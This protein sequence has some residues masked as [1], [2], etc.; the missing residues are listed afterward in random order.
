M[1]KWNVTLGM[2]VMADTRKQ[3]RETT[4]RICAG[5]GVDPVRV[6]DISNEPVPD[7]SS[8]VAI[9]ESGGK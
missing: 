6:I 1:Q 2:I 9:N 7:P 8:W 4:E 3:A 5:A